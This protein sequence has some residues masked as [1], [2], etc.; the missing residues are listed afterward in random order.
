MARLRELGFDALVSRTRSNT[1]SARLL[2]LRGIFLLRKKEL[3]F[4]YEASAPPLSS[5]RPKE[6]RRSSTEEVERDGYGRVWQATPRV[7]EEEMASGPA[8]VSEIRQLVCFRRRQ[9]L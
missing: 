6:V 8:P 1:R 9:K 5:R 3:D 4:F 2:L 7:G